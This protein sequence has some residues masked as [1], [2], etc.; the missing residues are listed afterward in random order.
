MV[1]VC[2]PS[3][4]PRLTHDRLALGVAAALLPLPQTASVQTPT[5]AVAS[6]RAKEPGEAG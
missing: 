3:F 2:P 6:A 4:T 1:Q 5:L